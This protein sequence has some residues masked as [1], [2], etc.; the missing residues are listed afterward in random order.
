MVRT[1]VLAIFML[2][3]LLSCAT[4][5]SSPTAYP[6]FR[7]EDAKPA[8]AVVRVSPGKYLPELEECTKPDVW[9]LHSPFWFNARLIEPVYGTLPR[10]RLKVST[11]SHYGMDAYKR[12]RA[13]WLV[14]LAIHEP[15]VIM[16]LYAS[17]G[18]ETRKDGSL[19]LLVHHPHDPWWLPCSV[20]QSRE[21]IAKSDFPQSPFIENDAYAVRKY[22]ELYVV[23]RDGAFPKFG[24]DTTRLRELL[25]GLRP[26]ADTM[27][28]KDDSDKS[29]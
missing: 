13:P 19:F 6:I 10:S 5:T 24:I 22:P 14:S 17:A 8:V 27:R 15:D 21:I 12:T 11:L 28:C 16:P 4:T 25:A 3:A 7:L 9:C 23:S 18:L 26:S 20:A 29:P 1:C 2:L